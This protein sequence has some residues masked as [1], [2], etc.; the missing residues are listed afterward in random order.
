MKKKIFPKISGHSEITYGEE[1]TIY[2]KMSQ[3]NNEY[4]IYNYLNEKYKNFASEYIPKIITVIGN[5]LQLIDISYNYKDA[6]M[7]DIK[8][9]SRKMKPHTSKYF[10]VKGYTNDKMFNFDKKKFMTNEETKI[11]FQNFLS[12]TKSVN[13]IINIWINK[14]TDLK[15]NLKKINLKLTGISLILIYD[16]ENTIED[17]K[18]ICNLYII[19]FAKAK[20]IDNSIYYDNDV[21]IAIEKII[22]YLTLFI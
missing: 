14:L 22:E 20:I 9:G 7:M 2:K 3:N 13:K 15:N 11:I 1:G 16:G 5:K 12:K 19:D 17:S 10:T 6:Y 18:E 8:I 4:I 21:F